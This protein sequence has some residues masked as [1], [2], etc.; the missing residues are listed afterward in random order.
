MHQIRKIQNSTTG[1]LIS[2]YEM[3]EPLTVNNDTCT[4]CYLCTEV[5]PN[6]IIIKPGSGGIPFRH[7]RIDLCFKCGQCMSVCST[8]SIQVKGLSYE[9]DFFPLPEDIGYENAFF[10]LIYS[11]RAVRNFHNKP[12]PK[13]FLEKIVNAISFAPPG[14]PPLK[15]EII[16]VTD[17][18]IIRKALPHM[19]DLFDILVKKMK[20][21]FFRF[22][23]EKEVGKQRFRT[24]RN[25]LIP[26][27]VSRLPELKE[28][29]EDTITRNAPA[30]ILFH[31]DRRGEDIKEDLYIAATYGMLAAHALGLGGSIMDI[32]PPAIDKKNELRAL[33]DV[34]ESNQVVASI[35]IGYPKYKYQR[36]IKRDLKS[37]K[38]L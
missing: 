6:K 13:E 36:G 34:P 14:F 38:W 33:F 10:N 27:L 5:C 9:K 37:I 26:L 31:T 29:I 18:E 35:I 7:D 8:K 4:R 23:I 20:N 30:M 22:F 15:T 12:V 21:P 28:G 3:N 11:R 25:H 17:P 2:K 24:M 19:I 16:V 1:N 32:I